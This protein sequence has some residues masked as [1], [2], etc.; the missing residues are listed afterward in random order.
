MRNRARVTRRVGIGLWMTLVAGLLLPAQ[1]A[2]FSVGS[3]SLIHSV[4]S[5]ALAWTGDVP[6]DN[7]YETRYLQASG[8]VKLWTWFYKGIDQDPHGDYYVV[9]S[10]ADWTLSQDFGPQRQPRLHPVGVQLDALD[11]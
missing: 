5:T 7:A 11:L 2:A 8:T 6:Y 3:S 10:R 4:C 1:A 9:T